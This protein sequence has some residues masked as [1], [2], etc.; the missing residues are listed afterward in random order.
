V[1]QKI[2][3]NG[4]AGLSDQGFVDD[5]FTTLAETSPAVIMMLRDG[6]IAYANPAGS[7]LTGYSSRDLIGRPITSIIHPDFQSLFLEREHAR[8]NGAISTTRYELK[9]LARSGDERWIDLVVTTTQQGR[10]PGA[11]L[12]A[13][14]IT[15][16]K[17][18]EHALREAERRMRDI[19]ENVRLVA[20]LRDVVGDITFANDF[21]IELLGCSE[22]DMVGVNWF[23]AVVPVEC[24]DLLRKNYVTAIAEGSVSPHE[25]SEVLTRLGERRTISWNHTLLHDTEGRIVGTA[26]IGSDVTER[27]RF[28]QQ[29]LHDA[30]HDALT[31]LPNRALFVDRLGS[32]LARLRRRPDR[33]LAVLFLDLDRFKLI[34]DSL[35]HSVGDELLVAISRV[36]RIAVRPGDTVARFG[37]DEFTV[38]LEDLDD[39]EEANAVAQRILSTLNVPF[40]LSGH[41]VFASASIGIA[42]SSRQ[43]EVPEDMLRDADIAMYRA[44][45]DGKSRHRVFDTSM[46]TQ[47]LELLALENDLR[48]A[49]DRKR[50]IVH[51]QPIVELASTDIVGVE[52]LVRW[53]HSQ[54]GLVWPAEFIGI[55]EETG[56]VVSISDHVLLQA[57]QD[58]QEW[59]QRYPFPVTVNVNISTRAFTQ[60]DLVERVATVLDHTRLSPDRLKLEITESALMENPESTAMMLHRFRELGTRIC[61][62]DFGTGY[63]SL[64]YLLRF[65]V[66]TLKI[67]RSFVAAIGRGPRNAQIV[68]AMVSLSKSLGMEVVAEG[69]ETEEQRQHLLDLGCTYAQGYLFS[70]PLPLPDFEA[71]LAQAARTRQQPVA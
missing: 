56:L 67:D 65:P 36:L 18:A 13:I 52:A 46:H 55:A 51:Y 25:E 69:V 42:L 66:D 39:P 11:L 32:A 23:D 50:F 43:Y 24:R 57:C 30:F 58:A 26:S 7:D 29:L 70:K 8:V 61:I 48:R 16:R 35:G 40:M 41:E 20:V 15:D 47:A 27:R 34:N 38:L 68:G 54:R 45:S 6:Q 63:S 44:K 5:R 33:L 3:R 2:L 31:G 62:D 19:L 64:S 28:E 17:L 21:V 12:M 22:E 71:L 1:I 9:L 59:E 60:P 10:T 4:L 49:V 14:D 53:D 37:G